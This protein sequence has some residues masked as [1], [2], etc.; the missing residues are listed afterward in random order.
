[1]Q[2]DLQHITHVPVL[3]SLSFGLLSKAGEKRHGVVMCFR[4]AA[5]QHLV[6]AAFLLAVAPDGRVDIKA[7]PPATAGLFPAS[8]RHLIAGYESGPERIRHQIE[9]R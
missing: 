1:D 2:G 8:R 7:G 4:R 3:P 5:A 6:V 9:E